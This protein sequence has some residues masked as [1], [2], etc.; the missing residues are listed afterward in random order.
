MVAVNGRG[1]EPSFE[2][3]WHDCLH[4]E[5]RIKTRAG[6]VHEE[7]LA[8]ATSMKKGKGKKFLRKNKGKGNQKPKSDML[9]IICYTCNK[10]GHCAK[11]CFSGKRK[12]RYHASIAEANEEP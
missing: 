9:K 5:S 6:L 11:D 8:L 12:G 10:P 7:N 1:V 4:E 3:L 2:K